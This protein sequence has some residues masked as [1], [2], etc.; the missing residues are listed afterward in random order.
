MLNIWR[1]QH[2]ILKKSTELETSSWIMSVQWNSTRPSTL[3]SGWSNSYLS[4]VKLCFV[5]IEYSP[6]T[7]TR[8]LTPVMRGSLS[9]TNWSWSATDLEEISQSCQGQVTRIL[10]AAGASNQATMWRMLEVLS[11]RHLVCQKTA[12]S[13]TGEQ[14]HW[15]VSGEPPQVTPETLQSHPKSLTHKLLSK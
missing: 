1:D 5:E 2:L 14:G 6:L 13:P 7:I 8:I 9:S 4:V 15:A 10:E 3:S 12:R 11:C